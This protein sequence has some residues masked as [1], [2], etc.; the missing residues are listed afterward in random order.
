METGTSNEIRTLITGATGFVGRELLHHLVA[1]HPGARFMALVRAADSGTLAIRRSALVAGMPPEQVNRVEVLRGDITAPRLGCDERRWRLLVERVDRVIHCAASTRFD[2]SLEDARR[3][4]VTSTRTM[5]ELCR[6]VAARGSSGRLDY[7]STAFVAG[8]RTGR[9]GEDELFVGQSF[10][11][12]YEQTKCEAEALCRAARAE[13]PVAIYRPSIVVGRQRTG[14]TT[15]YK[16]AY[17]P[18]RLLIAAYNRAPRLLNRLVPLP[19][20]PDLSVDLVPVDYVAAAMAALWSRDDAVG[21]CVHLAAGPDGAATLRE[22]VEITCDHFGTPQVRLLR[23]NR[24]LRAAGQVLAPLLALS[25]PKAAKMLAITYAYGLGMPVFDDANARAFGLT[26][27]SV[28]QFFRAILAFATARGFGARPSP[29][30]RAPAPDQITS[31]RMRR[32]A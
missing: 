1:Q 23:P 9:V 5:L 19:L 6:A 25:A 30:R 4:N 24:A 12:T 13:L 20:P 31:S 18:M 7:V 26:P 27:P 8:R 28:T 29:A 22:L 10:R 3:D 17:G 16:A 15:S 32:C 21:R 14:E 11:N 2:L